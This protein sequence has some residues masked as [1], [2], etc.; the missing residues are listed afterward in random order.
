MG[1]MNANQLL[2]LT[3]V[4]VHLVSDVKSAIDGALAAVINISGE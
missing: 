4:L 1:E 2:A 3:S